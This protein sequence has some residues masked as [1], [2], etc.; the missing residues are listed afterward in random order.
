MILGVDVSKTY[1][2]WCLSWHAQAASLTTYLLSNFPILVHSSLLTKNTSNA[3]K[4]DRKDFPATHEGVLDL[5][6]VPSQDQAVAFAGGS[7]IIS[8]HCPSAQSILPHPVGGQW[9]RGALFELSSTIILHTLCF[10]MW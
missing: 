5:G 6:T 4:I 9:G 8:R 1:T 3:L 7:R 2:S 10:L